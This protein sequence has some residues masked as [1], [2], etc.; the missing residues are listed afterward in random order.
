[1]VR[2][3]INFPRDSI[4]SLLLKDICVCMPGWVVVWVDAYGDKM[5]ASP[6]ELYTLILESG[7]HWSETIGWPVSSRDPP[8]STF[9]RLG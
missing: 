3:Y 4:F 9:P 1:M 2:N 8:V 7:S 6:Q 5:A